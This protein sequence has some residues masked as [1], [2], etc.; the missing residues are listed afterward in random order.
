MNAFSGLEELYLS[1]NKITRIKEN[2]FKGLT[3]LRTLHLTA[4]RLTEL[5][6]SET[7]NG[8]SKVQELELDES[9]RL[10]ETPRRFSFLIYKSRLKLLIIS[11]NLRNKQNLLGLL[12]LYFQWYKQ[13]KIF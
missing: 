1:F 3:G 11:K 8:L 10:N 6:K 9:V 4:N 2:T 5:F 13:I 12:N 7:I